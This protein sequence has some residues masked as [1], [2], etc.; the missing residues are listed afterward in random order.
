MRQTHLDLRN[1]GASLADSNTAMTAQCVTDSKGTKMRTFARGAVIV[2]GCVWASAS[3]ATAQST[4]AGASAA[5]S[6]HPPAIAGVAAV[7]PPGY[8]I[9]PEDHLS[10]VFWRDKDLSADVVVRPDGKISLPLL[11]DVVAGGLTPEELRR[12][13]TEEAKRYVED[14]TASV[15]V[16]EINSRKVFV[17]GLV[18]KPGIY[19]LAGPTTVLQL[20]ATAGGLQEYADKEKIVV[21]RRSNGTELAY[22]FNYKDVVRQKNP[23]Q[24]IEL[25]PGDT[26]VVP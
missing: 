10:V 6:S 26:V 15:I 11:N 16:R 22:K 3:Q 14:P 2:A 25:K 24:N 18:V 23:G 20:L 12:S 1:T 19:S 9:G 17:T 8:I 4:A 7:P 13:I 5:A 21:L